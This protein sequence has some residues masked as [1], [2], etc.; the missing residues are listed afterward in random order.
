MHIK[1]VSLYLPRNEWNIGSRGH[2]PRKLGHGRGS[3][4]YR[5]SDW[6]SRLWA[7]SKNRQFKTTRECAR[8][9]SCNSLPVQKN[10]LSNVAGTPRT[11]RW[12]RALRSA[13]ANYTR[14]W[15]IAELRIK[16]PPTQLSPW[17]SR[18]SFKSPHESNRRS[19]NR[20][21]GKRNQI[22]SLLTPT[23]SKYN[24]QSVLSWLN[25]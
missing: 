15:C 1:S 16:Q 13:E 5:R 24:K 19:T 7:M 17:T 25:W 12:T 3:A 10:S 23:D 2:H 18:S 11:A 21:R 22:A 20:P 6:T 4:P 8:S 9:L 14:S